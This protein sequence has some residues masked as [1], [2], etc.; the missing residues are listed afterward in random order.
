MIRKWFSFKSVF[1][2]TT[3]KLVPSKVFLKFFKYFLKIFQI[4]LIV[5]LIELFLKLANHSSKVRIAFL[6]NFSQNFSVFLKYTKIIWKSLD[7]VLI[8][9]YTSLLIFTKTSY[10]FKILD[11]FF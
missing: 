7:S 3:L 8:F 9:F 6:H 2:Q 10:F 1:A 4:L 5:S 11:K